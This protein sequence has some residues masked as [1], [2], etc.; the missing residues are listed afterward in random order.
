MPG[1]LPLSLIPLPARLA[2]RPGAFALRPGVVITADAPNHWNAAYL[3]RLLRPAGFQIPV[4]SQAD[5]DKPSIDLRIAGEPGALGREGYQLVVSP[6]G[7]ALQAPD[8]AGIFYG[9]QTLRQLLPVEIEGGAGVPPLPWEAPGCEIVD[10]PRCA[11]RGF[12][13]DEGRHFHGKDTVLRTLDLMAL[14]KL[15]VFHWHLTEDQGWRIEI[16]KYP[17]LTE[18]GSRRA[19]TS[20]GFYGAQDGVPHG[21]FYTQTEIREIVAYAAER[22]ITVVP[23]V[24]MPGHSLAALAA[25]PELSCAGGPFAVATRFGIHPEIYCAGKERVFAFLQ[26]VLD[27]VMALFPAPYIHIGGDEAPKLRW[28]QCPDCQ[29]RLRQEGLADVH[30]LQPYFTNRIMAYL[31]AHG[32]Q[33]VGWNEILQPGLA[34]N[35]VIQYWVRNRRALIEAVR[36]KERKVIVSAYLDTYLDH[37]YSLT[38]LSRAYTFEPVFP[39]LEAGDAEGILGLE[40]PLWTEFVPNRA[41]L[42][43]QTYPRLTAFAETGWTPRAAKNLQDFRR[44]LRVF[45]QR[46]ERL[47]VRHAPL[48]EVEPSKLS[49]FFGVLTIMQPQ[50]RTAD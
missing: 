14:Q 3:Q 4:Q 6:S 13:L 35:A 16:K 45:L 9:L 30:A 7:V 5:Q 32:R 29:R 11:W 39:E 15:N 47:G 2:R 36:R 12:M 31:K 40:A 38:P 50:T 22:H 34:E 21:G 49:Q 20:R 46:L 19:G 25:Y 37:S 41:R 27:E 17:R 42:D 23:E 24:E 28:S 26:D 33:A 43:Y 1:D 8:P 44:R 18:I 48:S 10:Q